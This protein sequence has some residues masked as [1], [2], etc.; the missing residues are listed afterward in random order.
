[1]TDVNELYT[2][3]AW[4]MVAIVGVASGFSR[5]QWLFLIAF[6]CA[7]ALLVGCATVVRQVPGRGNCVATSFA[8]ALYLTAAERDILE[9]W[10]ASRS[11]YHV[12]LEA[13][14]QGYVTGFTEVRD[15]PA[16]VLALENLNGVAGIIFDY[17]VGD[18]RHTVLITEYK[19]G[20][21]GARFLVAGSYSIPASK[22][23]MMFVDGAYGMLLEKEE[24]E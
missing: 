8:N 9:R 16:L 12:F 23:W 10:A 17:K 18:S 22:V 2:V 13:R 3:A 15:V 6:A 7:A 14:S 11:V 24:A 4:A 21:F 20:F 5:N 1:M 19:V